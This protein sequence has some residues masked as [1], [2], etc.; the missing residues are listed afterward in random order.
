L[1]NSLSVGQTHRYRFFDLKPMKSFFSHRT[2]PLV[3]IAIAGCWALSSFAR[4]QSVAFTIDDG[5]HLE[6]TPRLTAKARNQAMLDHLQKADV[7]A[8][9]F[10]TVNN[11]AN[12]PE[13]LALTNAWAEAGHT[14]GN[15]TM[16]HLD[17]HS[18][19]VTLQQY[20][21]EVMDCDAVISPL[22][23]YRKWFRFTYLREGNTPEKRDGMRA[24]LTAQNYRNAYVSLD[25]S[26]WRLNEKL[27]EVL[28]KDA[29][30]DVTPIK[31]AYLAHVRQRALAYRELSRTL[32]GR[33]IAQVLL[34][35]HN[36]INALWLGDVIA[37]FKQMGWSITTPD[38]AFKDPVYALQPNI[39]AAGQ[40][41][42][43]SMA[44][45]LGLWSSSGAK[46]AG[47]ERLHDDGDFEIE[48]LK[49]QGY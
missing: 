23:G 36:L 41:L 30:A 26:D 8:T 7:K 18:K 49:A 6:T 44:R 17:L 22:A 21:Q 40:S 27:I 12:R 13:G 32:Q 3:M 31:T 5:P 42:L 37:M 2:I 20:Q 38:E 15:H 46:F 35:H 43:L 45:S 47:W 19:G 9:L 14:I 29:N 34:L 1:K 11:G 4:A 48:A 33:D 28:S 10:V 39:P 25:T 16:S 24:F